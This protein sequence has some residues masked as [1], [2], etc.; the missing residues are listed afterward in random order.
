MCLQI[1][2]DIDREIRDRFQK[3]PIIKAF[4]F[5]RLKR[6]ES[7]DSMYLQTP[8]MKYRVYVPG[9][10]V[11]EQQVY[12]GKKTVEAKLDETERSGRVDY[13]IHVLLDENIAIDLC[14]DKNNSPENLSYDPFVC[15]PVYCKAKHFRAAGTFAGMRSAVFTQI[16]ILKEDFE[17]V[18]GQRGMPRVM[19]VLSPGQEFIASSRAT[20][21]GG[22]KV[23]IKELRFGSIR[24]VVNGTHWDCGI[25]YF[26]KDIARM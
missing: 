26:K 21:F 7:D 25:D 22:Q 12:H 20:Q 8:Y 2:S 10:I 11:A 19:P 4:K 3:E 16:E 6:G 17:R 18:I 24:F 9:T 13:G 23:T 1:Q 15:V 5:F 14:D